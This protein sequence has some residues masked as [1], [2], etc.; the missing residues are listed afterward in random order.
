MSIIE[1]VARNLDLGHQTDMILLDFSKAFHTVPH[2]RLLAKIENYGIQ[3]K[4]RNWIEAWLYHRYQT[5]VVEGERYNRVHVKSGIPQVTVLGPL[6][7]L[8]YINDIGDAVK[9]Q[10]RLFADDS[11][12]YGVVNGDEDAKALQ[13]DLDRLVKW[14]DKWQMT[15]NINK[16]RTL[17]VHRSKTTTINH[18]S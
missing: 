7:F 18:E 3:G 14:S 1:H 12:L 9:S 2:Q 5:V 13:E 6:M 10:I 15:F 17:R 8:I 4:V 11:L 16:C